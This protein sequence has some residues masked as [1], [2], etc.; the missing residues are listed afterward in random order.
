M[1]QG[2]S[3]EFIRLKIVD[4]DEVGRALSFELGGRHLGCRK[5][6]ASTYT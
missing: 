1:S 4:M 5:S 3:E 6:N 2:L